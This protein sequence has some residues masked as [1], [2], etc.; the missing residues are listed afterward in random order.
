MTRG[1]ATEADAGARARQTRKR[2]TAAARE[3]IA[4]SGFEAMSIEDVA[5][6]ARIGRSTF[7]LHFASRAELANAIAVDELAT[8]TDLWIELAN[9]DPANTAEVRRWLDRIVERWQGNSSLT[10]ISIEYRTDQRKLA[11]E[12]VDVQFMAAEAFLAETRRLGHEPSPLAIEE[13]RIGFMLLARFLY[14]HVSMN[15]PF[16][17]ES[18]DVLTRH[19]ADAM[20]RARDPEPAV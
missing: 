6:R 3:L 18:L 20:A 19:L 9:I 7:Y 1:T 11:A 2:I 4:E 13:V 8:L 14:L 5:E 15:V 17:N 10:V 12:L 16:E